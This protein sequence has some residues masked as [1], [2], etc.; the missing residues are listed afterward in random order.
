MIFQVTSMQ[1][2]FYPLKLTEVYP[3][4]LI[5]VQNQYQN[6][7][8]RSNQKNRNSRKKVYHRIPLTQRKQVKETI[9]NIPLN[10]QD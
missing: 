2:R 8:N 10:F 3:R 5:R 4:F 1:S 6:L 7:F 9:S